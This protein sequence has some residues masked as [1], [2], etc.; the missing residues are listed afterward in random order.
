VYKRYTPVD[1]DGQ[2]IT[3]PDFLSAS[4]VLLSLIVLLSCSGVVLCCD[5]LVLPLRGTCN[6]I[7][8]VMLVWALS[9]LVVVLV[10]SRCCLFLSWDGCLGAVL[11][12][13]CLVFKLSCLV[14]V[15]SC[16]VVL[17][18]CCSL[19]LSWCCQVSCCR[20]LSWAVS[21][22]V[23]L[24]CCCLVLLLS[25]VVLLLSNC[26]FLLL[27]CGFVSVLSFVVVHL[28]CVG[29]VL[30]RTCLVVSLSVCLSVVLS[31]L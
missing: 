1:L 30:S 27:W 10:L 3:F 19:V 14:W 29:G 23:V 4:C 15:L 22:G 28:S 8:C 31:W 26:Y 13:Y 2:N 9:S 18:C 17:L 11:S 5:C 16:L 6:V 20:V 7:V 12:C 24:S 21:L 25:C